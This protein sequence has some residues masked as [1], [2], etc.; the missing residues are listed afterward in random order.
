MDRIYLLIN[1]KIKFNISNLNC[2]ELNGVIKQLQSNSNNYTIKLVRY[3][4]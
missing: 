4:N 1:S 3:Y 2:K